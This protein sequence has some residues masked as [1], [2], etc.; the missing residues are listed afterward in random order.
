M[1]R[2]MA[3][4]NVEGHLQELLNHLESK[5]WRE[6]WAQLQYTRVTFED[7]GLAREASD[8]LLWQTCQDQGIILVTDNRN[9]K[10]P[11][12]LEATI[13]ARNQATNL[14]VITLSNAKRVM[15]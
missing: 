14:P 11:D 8:A 9:Q 3:D 5:A 7:L 6:L 2:I 12:S 10:G 13:R 15:L 4:N 1:P